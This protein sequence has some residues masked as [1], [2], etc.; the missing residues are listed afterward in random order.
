MK[1]ASKADYISRKLFDAYNDRW[2]IKYKRLYDRIQSLEASINGIHIAML[3]DQQ[4]PVE[5]DEQ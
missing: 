1:Y 5:E 3:E 2:I 4:D